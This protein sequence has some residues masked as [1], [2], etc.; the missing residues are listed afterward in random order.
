MVFS[1]L[2]FLLLFLPLVLICNFSLRSIRGKNLC[3]CL[4]SLLFYAWGEPT[5]LFLMLFM[6]GVNYV[7]ARLMEGKEK[8]S[9]CFA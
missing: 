2:V 7:L 5:Y 9:G 6:V 8:R 4:F 3:L 1:S